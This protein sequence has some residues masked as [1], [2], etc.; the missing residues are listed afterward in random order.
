MLAAGRRPINLDNGRAYC[1]CSRCKLRL[2]GYFFFSCLS[3][4]F[5]FSLS[6]G[7]MDG[8]MDDLGFYILFNR[9]KVLYQDDRWVMDDYVQW[10]RL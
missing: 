6:L 9:I 4:F 10:K 2:F 5:S 8:W 3:F 1:V 7:W